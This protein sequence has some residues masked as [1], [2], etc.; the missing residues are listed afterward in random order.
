MAKTSRKVTKGIF[1]FALI[2]VGS[3]IQ[4]PLTAL[5]S[6]I[7]GKSFTLLDLFRD[8]SLTSLSISMFFSSTYT[9]ITSNKFTTSI[10]FL[11]PLFILVC[12]LLIEI[13]GYGALTA[14]VE[15]GKSLSLKDEF[16]IFEMIVL[17]M[18]ISYYAVVELL[19]REKDRRYYN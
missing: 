10:W 9:L 5:L 19:L 12:S 1:F 3:L 16:V 6:Y 15:K 7:D 13:C 18:T 11:I 4:T 8:G 2:V 14:K 17:G